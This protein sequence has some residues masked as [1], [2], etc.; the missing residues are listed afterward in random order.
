M[1]NAE[2]QSESYRRQIIPAAQALVSSSRSAYA[3]GTVGFADLVDSERMLLVMRR[4][5]AEAQM[6]RE[7]RLVDLETLAGVDIETLMSATGAETGSTLAATPTNR[8]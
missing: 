2:R 8:Q 3:A 6:E 4:M 5:L 7:E 1:R